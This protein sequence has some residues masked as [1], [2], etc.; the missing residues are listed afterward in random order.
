MRS[1]INGRR[2]ESIDQFFAVS[3]GQIRFRDEGKGRPVVFLHGWTLDLE[4]WQPQVIA[5]CRQF[6]IIRFDRRGFGLSSGTPD[7]AQDVEDFRSLVN[8]LQLAQVAVVGMSQGARLAIRVALGM[9]QF[10]SALVLDGPPNLMAADGAGA[11]ESLAMDEYRELVRVRGVKAFRQ[12]WLQHPF[13]ELRTTDIRAR[14]LLSKMIARYPGHDLKGSVPTASDAIDASTLSHLRHPVLVVN[15]AKDSDSRRRTGEELRRA[16]PNALRAL[17]PDAGHLANLD[18]SE[19][20][21]DVL[22]G[23]LLRQARIAA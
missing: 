11:D 16:L 18:N 6:R 21:N 14:E 9:P 20:Y 23:F 13:V 3:G 12:I 5:L 1:P 15:G 19:F 7:P 10:V 2:M 22:S 17:I 8:H 4:M